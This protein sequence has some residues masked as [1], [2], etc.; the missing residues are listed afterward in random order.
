MLMTFRQIGELYNELQNLAT[1]CGGRLEQAQLDWKGPFEQPPT[2]YIYRPSGAKID[3]IALR[4][5]LKSNDAEQ[6]IGIIGTVIRTAE[7][8][9]LHGLW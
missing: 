7:Y 4:Y 8:A 3:A 1:E 6:R 9:R 5:S 2:F